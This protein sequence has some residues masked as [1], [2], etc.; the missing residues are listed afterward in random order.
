MPRSS[1]WSL[2]FRLF[3]HACYMARLSHSPL[4]HHCYNIWW[5]AQVMKIL[6]M[7]SSSSFLY[8]VLGPNILLS[9][10]CSNILNLWS[11]V[12]VGHLVSHPYKTMGKIILFYIWMFKL[13]QRRWEDKG[14]WTEWLVTSIPHI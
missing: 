4:L 8:F 2:S 7:Q 1:T 9:T 11:S 14:F 5:S 3:S 6:I 10:L 13:L 12:N